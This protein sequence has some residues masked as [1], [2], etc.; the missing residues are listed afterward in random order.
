MIVVDTN[1]V[2]RFVV[3][4]DGSADAAALHAED[5]EWAGPTILMSE[6]RNVMLGHVRRGVFGPNQA[7]SMCGEA[8]LI[9]GDRIEDVPHDRVISTALECGLSAYDAEFVVLARAL[10]VSLATLDREILAGAPDVAVSVREAIEQARR[11]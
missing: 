11:Q 6:L 7:M 4:D 2:V 3:G 10:G 9:L 5:P 8:A 1:V